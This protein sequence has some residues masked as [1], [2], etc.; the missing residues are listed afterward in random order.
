MWQQIA[1][2]WL[3][4]QVTATHMYINLDKLMPAL[5]IASMWYIG[6][7]SW[8]LCSFPKYVIQITDRKLELAHMF[9][10]ITSRFEVLWLQMKTND[11][12]QMI[13]V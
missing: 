12:F 8:S 9:Q 6:I 5:I 4:G 1:L 11:F 2:N 7:W 13:S 3:F 10:A